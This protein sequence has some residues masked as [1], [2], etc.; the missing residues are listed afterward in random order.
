M[1]ALT[2][3]YGQWEFF[4]FLARPNVLDVGAELSGKKRIPQPDIGK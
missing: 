4:K 3:R 2:E 1:P